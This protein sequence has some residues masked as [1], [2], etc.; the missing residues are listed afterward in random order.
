MI[1][2]TDSDFHDQGH[3]FTAIIASYDVLDAI[4]SKKRK[5]SM[6]GTFYPP[7]ILRFSGRTCS[8]ATWIGTL[9]PAHK[10]TLLVSFFCRVAHHNLLYDLSASIDSVMYM[11]RLHARGRADQESRQSA[12]WRN[13]AISIA[14]FLDKSS[15]ASLVLHEACEIEPKFRKSCRMI[16]DN[17]SDDADTP[18]QSAPV[19]LV[20]EEEDTKRRTMRGHEEEEEQSSFVP[21][22][23]L[24][25]S[26]QETASMV[27]ETLHESAGECGHAHYVP[28]SLT[29]SQARE[30]PMAKFAV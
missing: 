10:I 25:S 6:G 30:A 4:A 26:Q 11:E 24:S 7:D 16:S 28:C 15:P 9:W 18:S 8:L 1:I 5:F 21:C 3:F 23:L 20:A 27:P 2:A 22:S 13:T 17:D 29:Y 19:V 12:Q 14:S